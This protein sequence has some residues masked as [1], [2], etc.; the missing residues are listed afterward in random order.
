[1]TDL[2]SFLRTDLY[3]DHTAEDVNKLIAASL[4]SELANIET[5]SATRALADNDCPFQI[6]TA[7]GGDQIVKLAPLSSSNHVTMIYNSGASNNLI[8]KDDSATVTF[9]AVEPGSFA[10]L[11]PLLGTSWILVSPSQVQTSG[12]MQTSV[13]DPANI[14]EQLVGL[15][16]TQTLTKKRI[17]KRIISV[18]QSA[19]PS[20]NTDAGDIFEITGLAQNITSFT[21][22]GTPNKGDV[23]QIWITDNGASRTITPGSSFAGTAEFSLTGLAT[24]IG[25]RLMLLLQYTTIWELVGVL[26][27]A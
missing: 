19:T 2:S 10:F 14:A 1:M 7:S 11:A 8:V 25:K 4:R 21:V 13:Y 6:L 20:I 17:K 18:A 26:N 24:T 9:A 27:Q 15:N 16:A 23:M 5:I 22:T 3:D 12:F